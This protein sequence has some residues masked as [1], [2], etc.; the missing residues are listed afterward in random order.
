MNDAPRPLPRRLGLSPAA[1]KGAWLLSAVLAIGLAA[2]LLSRPRIGWQDDSVL[3]S[4][5]RLAEQRIDP[6]TASKASLVR[7][8]GIGPTTA[9]AIIHHREKYGA[10]AVATREGLLNV[11]G[12]G[13]L[14]LRAMRPHLDL[15]DP[16]G[17]T[18][19]GKPPGGR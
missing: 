7:L 18:G 16:C 19:T 17:V 4:R 8:P 5:V 3:P 12:I 2:W 11:P 9:E 15:A 14:R 1:L 10:S 13:P 6:R